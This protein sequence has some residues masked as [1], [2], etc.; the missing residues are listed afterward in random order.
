MGV[1]LYDVRFS[2]T[3]W[4]QDITS[5]SDC[6]NGA[7]AERKMEIAKLCGV[8]HLLKKVR[9]VDFGVHLCM[10]ACV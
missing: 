6:I 1:P 2:A 10:S 5:S 4:V 7:L 8:H 3:D 9:F